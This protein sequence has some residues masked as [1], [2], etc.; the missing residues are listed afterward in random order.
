MNATPS[1]RHFF[2]RVKPF[3]LLSVLIIAL[4]LF[5]ASGLHRYLTFSELQRHHQALHQWKDQHR[6]IAISAYILLYMVAVAISIPGATLLTLAGGF[7]FGPW[8]GTLYVMISA[9]IGST[10]IFIA[11][12]T[13]FS[14]LLQEKA[15]KKILLLK[16]GFEENAMSYLLFLRLVPLFP[17]WLINIVPG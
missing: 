5:F 13:A 14:S 7:L 6:L 1:R 2:T 9:T 8:L 15:G 11:A 16:K 4:L 10:I 3:L 12:K 17:F